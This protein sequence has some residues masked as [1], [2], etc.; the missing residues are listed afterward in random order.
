MRVL[1]ITA[2]IPSRGGGGIERHVY[3]LAMGLRK[4]G[5]D[6]T[7]ACENAIHFPGHAEDIRDHLKLIDVKRG[8]SPLLMPL[9]RNRS[10][11]ILL[12][13]TDYAVGNLRYSSAVSKAIRPE[14]YDVIHAHA[15]HGYSTFSRCRRLKKRPGLVMTLHGT[16]AGYY[17]SLRRHHLGAPVPMPD[18]LVNSW[19]EYRS[20]KA[21]DACIAISKNDALEGYKHYRVLESKTHVIYNWIDRSLFYPRDRLAARQA[22]GLD[23]GKQYLMYTGRAD[24]AKG[25][26]LLL[27]AMKKVG[28]KATLLVASKGAG[29]YGEKNMSNVKCLGYVDD[30]V[31][32][33]YYAAV[34]L[35]TLPSIYEGFGLSYLEAMSCGSVPIA[36]DEGPMN[37][38]V[39]EKVGYLCGKFEAGAYADTILK[40]LGEDLAQKRAASY[41]KS[42]T[43]DMDRSI[44]ETLAV[45]E[46]TVKH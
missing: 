28:D 8:T 9:K 38:I 45:Y 40:A 33:L 3:D 12:A 22:L 20:S 17:A 14:D 37:E 7:V 6:V 4:R 30:E 15:Q 32:P 42:L 25:Y 1:I 16:F 18:I 21:A 46:S 36:I 5:V 13:S 35:F 29:G 39:D 43:F 41:Q 11:S 31:L 19:M 26:F 10:L 27:D 24:G 44:D 23:P 2:F 34:D